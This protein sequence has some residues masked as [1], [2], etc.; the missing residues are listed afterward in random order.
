MHN[1]GMVTGERIRTARAR[2]GESQAEFARR[3]E[4]DQSTIARWEANGLPERGLLQTAVMRVIEE[5]KY[6]A[7]Q[8]VG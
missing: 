1:R 4:V 6:P 3:F 5:L 2:L 8:K 7:R